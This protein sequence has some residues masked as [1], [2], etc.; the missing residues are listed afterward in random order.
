MKSRFQTYRQRRDRPILDVWSRTEPRYRRR[1]AVLL[2]VTAMLFA[3]L[4]VFTYWLRTGSYAPWL[5][6]DYWS[7]FRHSFNPVGPEQVTLVDFLLFP[8]SVEDV[9]IQIIIMGLLLASLASVPILVAILYRLPSAMIFVAMIAILAVMPWYALTILLGCIIAS[10]RLI[11]LRFRYALAILGLLPVVVYFVMATREPE[12]TYAAMTPYRFKLYAPWVLAVLGSC[13]I[14]GMALGIAKIINYRP[15]GIAPVLAVLFAVPVLLFHTQVGRDELE[16][17]LLEHR[18]G[19]NSTTVFVNRDLRKAEEKSAERAWKVARDATIESIFRRQITAAAAK[20]AN[21]LAGNRAEVVRA[22]D[23]FMEYYRTSRYVPCVL[24]IKGRALDM[25]IS[26]AV[27]TREDRIEHYADV[28]SSQ[29]EE[30]W[31]LL[32]AQDPNAETAAVAYNRLAVLQAQVG[33]VAGALATL[34]ALLDG[35]DPDV[36]A[37]QPAATA[38]GTRTLLAKKPATATLG[39]DVSAEVQRAQ[40]LRDL[41]L[42]TRDEWQTPTTNPSS[43]PAVGKPTAIQAWCRLDPHHHAFGDNLESIAD[44]FPGSALRPVIEAQLAMIDPSLPR[45]LERLTQAEQK[46]SGKPGCAEVLLRLAESLKEAARFDDA[47]RV[48]ERL[49]SDYPASS[50]T[51]EARSQLGSL[52]MSMASR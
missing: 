8:I 35:F 19:P 20:A 46:Y 2:A 9:P 25:R 33:D 24:F 36:T 23:E 38:R 37:T 4:C 1:A 40:R 43:A 41:I 27:L 10:G 52:T 12:S 47:A 22:C 51:A 45:Q 34:E 49:K 48:Y 7:L 29:S 50:W 6:G 42:I 18:F 32:L 21:T 5:S 15:G 17:R 28:S 30:T 13:V 3:G 31:R 14:C 11:Q 44:E 26:D 16:F 39:V